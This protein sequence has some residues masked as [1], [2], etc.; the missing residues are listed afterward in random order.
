MGLRAGADDHAL[1]LDEGVLHDVAP[2]AGR[3]T[4]SKRVRPFEVVSPFWGF[5]G[6]KGE[7]N[8]F[9]WG[10]P[11]KDNTKQDIDPY[12]YFYGT[13]LLLTALLSTQ[14][15]LPCCEAPCPHFQALVLEV[16]RLSF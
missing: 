5:V 8:H 13:G 6:F 2:E 11:R 12:T 3:L 4:P 7:A 9:F 10:G 14:R 1:A 16:M 15:G